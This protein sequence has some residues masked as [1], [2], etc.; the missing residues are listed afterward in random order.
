ME[1]R[2]IWGHEI[3][4]ELKHID[5]EK[6]QKE[7]ELQNLKELKVTIDGELEERSRILEEQEIEIQD[8]DRE[9][10]RLHKE[11][12]N[13][14][15]NLA[16]L[17][18]E[19]LSKQDQLEE[20][21]RKMSLMQQKLQKAIEKGIEKEK[22]LRKL[23]QELENKNDQI[24]DIT[25]EVQN[26]LSAAEAEL[27]E[28]IFV[29]SRINSYSDS[30]SEE[31]ATKQL[32]ENFISLKDEL[33]ELQEGISQDENS[34]WEDDMQCLQ[35]NTISSTTQEMSDKEVQTL[36]TQKSHNRGMKYTVFFTIPFALTGVSL[37][38]IPLI[39][40]TEN[41][42]IFLSVGLSFSTLAIVCLIAVTLYSYYRE[43][44]ADLELP[45]KLSGNSIDNII[46]QD[47]SMDKI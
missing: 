47:Y 28:I 2:E 32:K 13:K 7:H 29:K 42:T 39:K 21:E 27:R 20:I 9:L 8:K 19:I 24:I 41:D 40:S 22:I 33:N 43:S 16:E 30:E 45:K 26:R 37:T 3:L 18:N 35:D 36:N 4:E 12:E 23:N 25:I 1:E 15:R 38:V 5:E 44:V 6:K 17:N 31:F 11:V 46:T 14:N 34:Y 10:G